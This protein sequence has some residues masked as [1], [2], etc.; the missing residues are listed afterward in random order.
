ME[1]NLGRLRD[2]QEGSGTSE[3]TTA[4]A[5]LEQVG[6]EGP[7]GVGITTP[8]SHHGLPEATWAQHTQLTAA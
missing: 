5:A 2:S 3:V 1:G 8:H 4:I 6:W 7:A